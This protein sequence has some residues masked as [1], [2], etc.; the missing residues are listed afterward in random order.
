[1]MGGK[2]PP[3]SFHGRRILMKFKATSDFYLGDELIK[4]ES[5]IDIPENKIKRCLEAKVGV[6]LEEGGKNGAENDNSATGRTSD[7]GG[8][9]TPIKGG[10]K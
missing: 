7:I 4:A 5:V 9:K 1:M 6:A 3:L 8:S 10:R 2:K